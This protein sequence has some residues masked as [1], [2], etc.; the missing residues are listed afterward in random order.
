MHRET[1]TRRDLLRGGTGLAALCLAGGLSGCR[2]VLGGDGLPD[3][4]D[5]GVLE[6]V[7][8]SAIAAAHVEVDALLGDRALR[9]AVDARLALFGA[10]F[11]RVP[12][13]V[14]AG[15][16]RVESRLGLDPG[17]V[18]E[19]VTFV[20]RPPDLVQNQDGSGDE[21]DPLANTARGAIVWADW[22]QTAVR[23]ALAAR[24]TRIRGDRHRG[25][26]RLVGLTD[27]KPFLAV[28][29]P[30]DGRVAIGDP[31]GVGAALEVAAGDEPAR[32]GSLADALGAARP[33]V[34]RVA[35]APRQSADR[36]S[37]F[38][39]PVALLAGKI[40]TA[41]GTLYAVDERRGVE[42]VLEAGSGFDAEDVHESVQSVLALARSGGVVPYVE[43]IL[44]Q[45]EA[46]RSGS[47]VTLRYGGPV[48]EFAGTLLSVLASFAIQYAEQDDGNG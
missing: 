47:T 18:R 2:S 6:H 48:D 38:G 39:D 1:A 26:R 12:P 15:L 16:D 20:A 10:V 11:D 36:A 14:E 42:L 22:T 9:D 5:P 8:D 13:T 37:G 3:R 33:G 21:L 32:E 43:P 46:T 24:A 17:A 25:Y 23:D 4:S 29:F 27:G 40:D 28:G 44:R 19:M 35:V 31:R 34:A 41:Y 30:D 45:V 7:P